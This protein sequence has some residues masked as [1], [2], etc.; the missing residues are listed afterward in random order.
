MH[1]I[2]QYAE[3]VPGYT[4][5]PPNPDNGGR[6]T[7]RPCNQVWANFPIAPTEASFNHI[8]RKHNAHMGIPSEVEFH[9]SSSHRPGNNNLNESMSSLTLEATNQL[10]I[11]K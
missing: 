10:F 6:F 4:P 8:L 11:K 2:D 7:G 3:W 9:L 5:L 1:F